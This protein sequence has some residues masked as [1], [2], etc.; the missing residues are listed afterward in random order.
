MTGGVS[1]NLSA[2]SIDQMVKCPDPISE[3][4]VH[5][6]AKHNAIEDCMAV[7]K[8]AF[9]NDELELKE[10]LQ[11]IRQLSTKQAKQM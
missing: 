8:K 9:E 4:I 6:V 1:G 7:V 3:K 10:F 5:L 11:N 2:D